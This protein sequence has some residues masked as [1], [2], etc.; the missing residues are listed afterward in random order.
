MVWTAEN[1]FSRFLLNEMPIPVA[2]SNADIELEAVNLAAQKFF[3][4]SPDDTRVR[5]C[6]E[7]LQ[8]MNASQPE[9][10][11]GTPACKNCVVRSSIV[12][13]LQ[14]NSVTRNKGTFHVIKT[15]EVQQLTLLITTSPIH[16]QN[17]Q[18]VIVLIE[19]ISLITELQGLLP[20]CSVCHKIRNEQ[21]EWISLE[22]YIKNHSE[23]E[24]THDYCPDCIRAAKPRT[25]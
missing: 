7:V 6:G 13:A 20:I 22:R 10:C 5:S 1:D 3:C 9:K 16:Y 24:F 23:A 8:C 14:G 17:L 4:I 2:I 18:M 19:D 25:E 21:G 11:G 12:Q 15:Q